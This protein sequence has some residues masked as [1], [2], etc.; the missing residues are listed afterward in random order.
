[1]NALR[2]YNSRPPTHI[3]H[4]DVP[5]ELIEIMKKHDG[6]ADAFYIPGEYL[7]RIRPIN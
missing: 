1:L 5:D 2:K 3:V 4:A 6:I 7:H